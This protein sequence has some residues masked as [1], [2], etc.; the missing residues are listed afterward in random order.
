LASFNYISPRVRYDPERDWVP[1]WLAD[2]ERPLEFTDL[3]GR[4]VVTRENF[5]VRIANIS[6]QLNEWTEVHSSLS[7]SLTDIAHFEGLRAE[8]SRLLAEFLDV[9][10][11]FVV[12]M[13]RTL[14]E[15][16][17]NDESALP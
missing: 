3:V 11:G 17:R 2:K 8:R 9:E 14:G 7:P 1:P 4:Y 13:L 12:Q 15:G 5:A 6:Q 16:A 10:D